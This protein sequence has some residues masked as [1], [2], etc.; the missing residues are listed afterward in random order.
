MSFALITGLFAAIY[1]MMPRAKIAWRDVWIGAVVTALLFAAGKLPDRPVPRQKRGDIGFR[2]GGIHGGAADLGLL[3][4]AEL[5][6]RRG[7]TRVYAHHSGSRVSAPQ[8][9]PASSMPQSTVGFVTRESASTTSAFYPATGQKLPPRRKFAHL[10][11]P[12]AT[13][14]AG[15]PMRNLGMVV[16]S[17]LV[18]G[19]IL[20]RFVPAARLLHRP[21]SN[22]ARLVA[23]VRNVLSGGLFRGVSG[24]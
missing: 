3:L 10:S 7:I 20:R 11:A 19:T 5:F 17:G 18:V 13:F 14:V 22:L 8:E 9:Q 23:R 16:F 21:P 6:V 12:G 24:K 1:K 4:R 2:C 15:H